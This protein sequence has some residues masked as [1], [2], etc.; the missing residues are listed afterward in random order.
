[1]ERTDDAPKA[2]VYTCAADAVPF[3]S[4]TNGPSNKCY[5]MACQGSK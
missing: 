5:E 3:P 1:M 2:N 4:A